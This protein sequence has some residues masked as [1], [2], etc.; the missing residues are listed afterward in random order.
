MSFLLPI[1]APGIP[2]LANEI[3]QVFAPQQPTADTLTDQD[4]E[5]DYDLAE[6]YSSD[7]F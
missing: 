6:D 2:W 5:P 4:Q 7:D 1:I 3:Q